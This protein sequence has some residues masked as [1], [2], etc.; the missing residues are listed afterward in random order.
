MAMGRT[1]ALSGAAVY[2]VYSQITGDHNPGA[3]AAGAVACAG[4]ALMPDWDHPQATVARTFGPVTRWLT[5]FVE[6]VSLGHRKLTHTLLAVAVFT[7]VTWLLVSLAD[8]GEQAGLIRPQE[9]PLVALVALL[10]G[11]ALRALRVADFHRE[12]FLGLANLTSATPVA[13]LYV[14]LSPDLSVLLSAVPLGVMIHLVGDMCTEGGCP[15]L[16]PLSWADMWVLPKWLRWQT[17]DREGFIP[18]RHLVTPA[19]WLVVGWYGWLMVRGLDPVTM[20][21]SSTLTHH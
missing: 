2:L 20:F 16:A 18:E 11:S 7:A 10:I 3:V 5:E 6:L 17:T 21:P 19:L 1:H 9:V 14:H 15:L 4:A 13:W 8:T 12:S